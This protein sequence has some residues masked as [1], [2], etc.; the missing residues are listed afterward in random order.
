MWTAF[1]SSKI[2]LIPLNLM[3]RTWHAYYV[4]TAILTSGFARAFKAKPGRTQAFWQVNYVEQWLLV[5]QLLFCSC[6]PSHSSSWGKPR[7]ALEALLTSALL[8]SLHP[9]LPS[10]L[11]SHFWSHS[12]LPHTVKSTFCPACAS[13]VV[14]ETLVLKAGSGQPSIHSTSWRSLLPG[15]IIYATRDGALL[16][17]GFAPFCTSFGTPDALS[18]QPWCAQT[19]AAQNRVSLR[20]AVTHDLLTVALFCLV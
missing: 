9:W 20:V 7:R 4:T 12:D 6:P 15:H 14:G 18:L 16:L 5:K 19:R 10:Y 3:P 17:A 13:R 11:K 8:G 1:S 2:L